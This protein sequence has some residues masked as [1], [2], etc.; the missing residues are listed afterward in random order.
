MSVYLF[1]QIPQAKMKKVDLTHILVNRLMRNILQ[2]FYGPP[3]WFA[4]FCR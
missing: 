3:T 4:G 1:K 2:V